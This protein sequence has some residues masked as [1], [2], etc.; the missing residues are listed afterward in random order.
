VSNA[1]NVPGKK[2]TK[3]GKLHPEQ[4][5]R[6]ELRG[7]MALHRTEEGEVQSRGFPTKNLLCV[8]GGQE[9]VFAGPHLKRKKTAGQKVKK[10]KGR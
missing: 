8:A 1:S 10:Q 6:R 4:D 3:E 9:K 7:G 5:D 2:M